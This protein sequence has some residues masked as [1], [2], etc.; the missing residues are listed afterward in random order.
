MNDTSSKPTPI[1]PGRKSSLPITT[2][3]DGREYTLDPQ[4]RFGKSPRAFQAALWRCKTESGQ[5]RA[6]VISGNRV[7]F[8]W[9]IAE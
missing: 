1:K 5:F 4:K 8:Y 7:R 2:W 6:E 3:Q 9:E